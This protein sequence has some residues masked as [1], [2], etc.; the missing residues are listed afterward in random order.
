MRGPPPPSVE[1]RD[2][3]DELGLLCWQLL[4]LGLTAPR[5]FN[6]KKTPV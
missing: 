5:I 1:D 3:L 2:E 6:E 4:L